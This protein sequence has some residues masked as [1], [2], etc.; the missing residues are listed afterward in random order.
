MDWRESFTIIAFSRLW[1]RLGTVLW[2]GFV[3]FFLSL[4]VVLLPPSLAAT[5]DAAVRAVRHEEFGFKDFFASGRKFFLR[6]WVLF[7][8]TFTA[9]GMVFF[10]L[11]F[12]AL[13]E[14]LVWTFAFSVT[15]ALSFAAASVAPFL[16]PIMVR[17]DLGVGETFRYA[18][19][20]AFRKPLNAISV[21]LISASL[22]ALFFISTVGIIFLWPVTMLFAASALESAIQEHKFEE[23]Q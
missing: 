14:G 8:L 4:T 12:Y 2:V 17:D 13:Q 9:A 1:D 3:G 19:Y 7:A 20:A 21:V 15:L 23:K 11:R 18:F 22:A 16:F 5:A 10:N 6:S